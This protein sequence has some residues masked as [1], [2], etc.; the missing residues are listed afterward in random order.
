[1]KLRKIYL[2]LQIDRL[3][4]SFDIDTHIR[5]QTFTNNYKRK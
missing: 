3:L 5:L 2:L 1:L 4:Q